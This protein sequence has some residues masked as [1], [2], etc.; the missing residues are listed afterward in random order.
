MIPNPHWESLEAPF[1]IVCASV[2][3][4]VSQPNPKIDELLSQMTLAEKIAMIHGAPEDPSTSQAQPG[5]V[6]GVARLGR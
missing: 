3:I 1:L 6:A 4:V 2:G 5:Y